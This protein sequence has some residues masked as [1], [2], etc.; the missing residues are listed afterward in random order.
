MALL[1]LYDVLVSDDSEAMTSSQIRSS[2]LGQ[3]SHNLLKRALQDLESLGFV[4]DTVPFGS[5]SIWTLTPNGITHTE[6]M[7]SDGTTVTDYL[8]AE[9]IF[10]STKDDSFE[11]KIP[12]ADR[13]V[14]K[15]D[16]SW[17][18]PDY[19]GEI[20]SEIEDQVRDLIRKA[21]DDLP[22][23]ELSNADQSQALARLESAQ[24]LADAPEPQ[25]RKVCEIL[26][27]MEKIAVI[28]ASIAMI[29]SVLGP[30][31]L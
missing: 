27:P 18:E 13:Y 16:N 14:A 21:I 12:A 11:E 31:L 28:G 7:K 3:M 2:F 4:R 5:N 29:L 17:N 25:W 15:S 20:D 23:A 1:T 9:D 6:N 26:A 10:P 8:L 22:Q 24:K 19:D 30:F